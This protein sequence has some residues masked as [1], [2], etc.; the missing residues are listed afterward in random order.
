MMTKQAS[1]PSSRLGAWGGEMKMVEYFELIGRIITKIKQW[2]K[3]FAHP[4]AVLI[5]NKS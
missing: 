3:W 4:F 5:K 1:L 2:S